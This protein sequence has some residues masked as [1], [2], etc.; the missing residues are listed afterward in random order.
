MPRQSTRA[1][2]NAVRTFN[3]HVLNPV[4][5]L[6]AGR[7]HWYAAAIRHT[8]R[9][10]GTTHTTPVVAVR[11]SDGF[12]TPLPYG[13]DVD[14]LR[15]VLAAGTATITADGRT[16]DV[17]DPRII[18]AATAAQELPPHRRRAFQRFRIQHYVKFGLV[19]GEGTLHDN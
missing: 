1:A 17:V 11:V 7:R 18:D 8:G 12:I 10:T 9:R 3:K 14:W 16:F 4:M 19:T 13:T 15:N 2:N 6:L 5:L